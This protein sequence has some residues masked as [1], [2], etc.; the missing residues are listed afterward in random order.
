[1]KNLKSV[2]SL[3][4]YLCRY[5]CVKTREDEGLE[6][7]MFLWRQPEKEGGEK[8]TQKTTLRRTR[9]VLRRR[10]STFS[11]WLYEFIIIPYNNI[12]SFGSLSF[13]ENFSTFIFCWCAH[14]FFSGQL[15]CW[16]HFS[17]GVVLWL[18]SVPSGNC[19]IISHLT[20]HKIGRK[21]RKLEK[22]FEDK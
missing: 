12:A 6:M 8:H 11:T 20:R 16:L 10:P 22:L 1:M 4:T 9:R 18:K 21:K 14:T 15:V 2:F 17:F 3:T 5:W 13:K 7:K 19:Q